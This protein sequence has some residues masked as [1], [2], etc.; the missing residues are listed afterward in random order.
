MLSGAVISLWS[1]LKIMPGGGAVLGEEG[2]M[3]Q[4]FEPVRTAFQADVA[5]GS[6][7]KVDPERAGPRMSHLQSGR[8]GPRTLNRSGPK[9][10]GVQ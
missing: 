1:S 4:Y 5:L 10:G 9:Q 3:S 6:L 8:W 7:W 2:N